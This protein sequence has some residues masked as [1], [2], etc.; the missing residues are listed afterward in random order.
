MK[1]SVIIP[2]YNHCEDYLKPCVQSVLQYS[3]MTDVELIISANGCVDHTWA[4]LRSL[5]DQFEQIGMS[6]HLKVIWHDE[7]LGYSKANNVAIA[8]AACDHVVLLNNDCVLLPQAQNTWLDQLNVPFTQDDRMGVSGIV[9]AHDSVTQH[10]FVIFFCVM[11]HKRVFD[12][13]GLLNE[14]YQVGGCEDVEFCVKAVQAGFTVTTCD[15]HVH[16]ARPGLW[17]GAFPIYH[18]GQGTLLDTDLVS[19]WSQDLAR[20]QHKLQLTCGIHVR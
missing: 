9:Q 10:E 12:Q 2:T 6:S 13:I 20:N 1:Y 5:Q 3:C 18:K 11:I 4:Y 16:T 7:P 15:Q 17:S 8:Q 19:D 14:T